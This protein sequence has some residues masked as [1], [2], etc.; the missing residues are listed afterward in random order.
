MVRENLES[1]GWTRRFTIEA[2]RADEYVELH[3][4]LGD[5]VRV[6]ALTPDLAPREECRA[7]LVAACDEY[8]VIYTRP[9]AST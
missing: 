5:Q 6:E 4:S 3:E 8:V 2:A 1:E 7:C 9:R